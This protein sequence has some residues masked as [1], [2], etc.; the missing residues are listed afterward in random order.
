MMFVDE[1]LRTTLEV[2]E[3][4]AETLTMRTVSFIPEELV[5]Q[6]QKQ[7]PDLHLNYD[8]D[9]VKQAISY[10]LKMYGISC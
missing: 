5:H 2:I 3:A 9:L 10:S 4:P 7:L 1:C 6:I 8:V